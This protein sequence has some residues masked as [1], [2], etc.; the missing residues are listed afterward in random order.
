MYGNM[1]ACFLIISHD[2]LDWGKH[3]KALL[4]ITL[5]RLVLICSI[6]APYYQGHGAQSGS[7]DHRPAIT[8]EC[9]PLRQ[10]LNILNDH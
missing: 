5:L 6:F 8:M 4:H 2:P 9:I 3:G 1:S 7:M 10:I